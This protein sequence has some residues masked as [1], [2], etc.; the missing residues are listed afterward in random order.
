MVVGF[1]L[2]RRS[3][4]VLSFLCLEL[5]YSLSAREILA[6]LFCNFKFIT[7]L[8]MPVVCLCILEVVWNGSKLQNFALCTNEERLAIF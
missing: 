2:D 3:M 6:F 4:M 7:L 1:I 5:D 8:D